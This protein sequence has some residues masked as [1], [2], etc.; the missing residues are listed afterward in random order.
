MNTNYIKIPVEMALFALRE[1]KSKQVACYT[2]SQ[3]LFSG[4][5]HRNDK[6]VQRIANTI[7]VS[8]SSVYR[9]FKW[10]IDRNWFGKSRY[11][12]YYF[13]G[14]DKIHAIENWQFARAVKMYPK[15]LKK[16]KAFMTG[17]VCASLVQTGKGQRRERAKGRSKQT[18]GLIS[19]S[20]LA[21][22]LDVSTKTAYRLRKLADNHNYIENSPTLTEITNWSPN[23]LKELKR[24]DLKYLPVELLGYADKKITAI[25]RI[26]YEDDKLYLQEP[27]R[28]KSLLQL[29][30]RKGLSNYQP[31]NPC[32]NVRQK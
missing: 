24:Q 3:F 8:N 32:N 11:G 29:K 12:R 28:I 30:S 23:D 31:P 13:R 20:V 9:Y 16:I 10:L 15:D 21:N 18:V 25:D 19:L 14:I 26:R 7:E 5:A 4:N 2:A 27:N 22:T 6:P 17:A 1:Q